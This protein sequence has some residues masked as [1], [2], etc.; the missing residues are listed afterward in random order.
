[1]DLFSPFR[2]GGTDEGSQ[3][4]YGLGLWPPP[5][6]RHD[7]TRRPARRSA[8]GLKRPG[9]LQGPRCG[10]CCSCAGCIALWGLRM[11]RLEGYIVKYTDVL[12]FG[13]VGDR[14]S[15]DRQRRYSY[16]AFTCGYSPTSRPNASA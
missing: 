4:V 1:M 5:S 14:K 10:C 15:F 9:Y 2:P 7:V 6:P 16:N 3:V 12:P 13:L 11:T 8:P